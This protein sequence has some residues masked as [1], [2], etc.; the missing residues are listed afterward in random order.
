VEF[1]PTALELMSN[2]PGDFVIPYPNINPGACAI[3]RQSCIDKVGYFDELISP[4]YLYFE[5]TDFIRRMH[6][7]GV[8]Q[9][10]CNE[11]RVVHMNGGSQTHH[12]TLED[13][14]KSAN[15]H[16]RFA[17]AQANYHW[18]WGGLPFEEKFIE[19]RPLPRSPGWTGD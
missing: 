17:I 16:H 19:P 15:H 18:K 9:T 13:P 3:I 4:G 14:V 11:A 8:E 5:D 12:R 10:V 2:T 6:L 7:A 1:E